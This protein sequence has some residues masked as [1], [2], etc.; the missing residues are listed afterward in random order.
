[1]PRFIVQPLQ[2]IGPVQFGMH[3]ADVRA[4]MNLPVE[5]F[6]QTGAPAATDAYL[7]SCFQVFYD[8]ADTVEY[9]ELS[10]GGSITAIYGALDIFVTEAEQVVE[11]IAQEAAVDETDP[12]LGYSYVFPALELSLW[13]PVLPEYEQ[14][15]RYFAT[16]GVGRPGY[17]SG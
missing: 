2:G 7:E 15:G 3:R 17:Y 6:Q 5:S 1:M 10:R 9:I 12:E 8:A 14:E 16:I 11:Q 13:R 4:A